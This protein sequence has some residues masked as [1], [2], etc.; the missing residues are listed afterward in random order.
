MRKAEFTEYVTPAKPAGK[1]ERNKA[2][3]RR[4]IV[5]AATELF[6]SQGFGATTTASIAEAAGV[7]AGTVYLYVESKED[8][9]VHVFAVDAGGAWARAFDNVDPDAAVADQMLHLFL[10][11]TRHHNRDPGLAR[12]YFKELPFVSEQVRSEVVTL[13][14]S[15]IN[16]LV[17]LLD[18]AIQRG[19]LAEHVNTMALANNLFSCWY[20]FMQRYFGDWFDSATLERHL[21][22]SVRT[23]FEGLTP[24]RRS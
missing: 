13:T 4:K 17:E 20:Q 14:R 12:A 8:L 23:A 1:R 5:E 21:A 7:G 16:G 22:A 6:K 15:L 2:E 18:D 9:L 11:V 10:A 3:K 24:P 19:E